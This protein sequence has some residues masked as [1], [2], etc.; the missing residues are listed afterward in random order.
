MVSNLANGLWGVNFNYRS[1]D[2]KGFDKIRNGFQKSV[3]CTYLDTG[4]RKTENEFDS[5]KKNEFIFNTFGTT[6]MQ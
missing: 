2:V 5:K 6:L 4:K 3:L 1:K